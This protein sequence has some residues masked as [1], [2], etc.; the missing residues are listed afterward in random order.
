[1][2]GKGRGR[3]KGS[4]DQVKRSQGRWSDATRDK[5]NLPPAK[6]TTRSAR[7]TTQ[8]DVDELFGAAAPGADR[9]GDGRNGEAGASGST[10]QREADTEQREQRERAI[11][12]QYIKQ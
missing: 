6:P 12:R 3:P 5:H 9:R 7:P 10:E 4:V 8:R 2:A 11:E 1:M